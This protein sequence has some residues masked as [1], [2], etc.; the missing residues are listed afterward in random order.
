ML[1]RLLPALCLCAAMAPAWS[2]SETAPAETQPETAASELQTVQISGQRP[3]PGLWKVSSG[4]HVL[5]IFGT[6]G[7]L[8]EKMEWRSQQVESIL[9]QS[10]EYIGLP[11]VSIGVGF[12]RGLTVLPFLPGVQNNPDG[13]KLKDVVPAETYARWLALKEKYIGKDDGIERQRPFFAAEALMRKGL[14]HAGLSNGSDVAKSIDK[15]A[16]QHNVKFTSMHVELEFEDPVKTVRNFKKSPMDDAACFAKTLDRLETDIG[17]MRARAAA[18]AI[19]DMDVI[20]KVDFNTVEQ[21]CKDAIFGAGGMRDQTALK[22]TEQRQ[23]SKWLGAAEKA[24]AANNSTFALLSMR[25]LMNPNGLLAELQAK[26]YKV[27]APE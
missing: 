1:K 19:G 13:A 27:Q 21:A 8:P 26:G 5:W 22:E 9:A 3:G 15:L 24:L 12:F 14:S 18:W 7:P 10:Q 2:Q 23:R 25:E 6:Y 20:R 11:G 16:K 17:V 4:D